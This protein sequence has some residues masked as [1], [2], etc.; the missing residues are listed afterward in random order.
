MLGPNTNPLAAASRRPE[1]R[2]R[3]ALACSRPRAAQSNKGERRGFPGF[4]TFF[5]Q[6]GP[7]D[8]FGTSDDPARYVH[9]HVGDFAFTFKEIRGPI[10]NDTADHGPVAAEELHP[11]RSR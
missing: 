2:G 6:A 1:R 5:R 11:L 7:D 9:E 10:G 8:Q 3:R 4:D